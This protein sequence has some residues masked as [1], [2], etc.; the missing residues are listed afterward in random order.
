[1]DNSHTNPKRKRGAHAL[2]ETVAGVCD[3]GPASQ[4]PATIFPARK[5]VTTRT[6]SNTV[7]SQTNCF[8]PG[9]RSLIRVASSTSPP[10]EPV[11]CFDGF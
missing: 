2:K 4:R 3:P 9:Q 8:R 10:G 6:A 11:L 1:M 7:A 5:R